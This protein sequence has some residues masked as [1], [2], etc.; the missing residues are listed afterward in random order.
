MVSGLL[1]RKGTIAAKIAH[2]QA[3]SHQLPVYSRIGTRRRVDGDVKVRWKC[4]AHSR[5]P[6]QGYFRRMS[7][8]L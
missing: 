5:A 6:L 3:F 7:G 1:A 4:R 2:L 8:C